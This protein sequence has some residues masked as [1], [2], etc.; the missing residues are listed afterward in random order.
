MAQNLVRT[1]LFVAG[2]VLIGI[3]AGCA[4][5]SK[6]QCEAGDWLT[7]GLSDGQHGR[8]LS[9]FE[10]HQSACA[11]HG[12]S[13]NKA[14]YEDGRTE[15]LAAYC[16]L[17]VAEREGLAGRPY[18]SV[19]TGEM[20]A[21]FYHVHSSARSVYATSQ[22]IEVSENRIDTLLRQLSDPKLPAEQRQQVTADLTFEQARLSRLIAQRQTREGELRRAIVEETQRLE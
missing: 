17:E 13:V 4:T 22:E 12:I 20:G 9:R 19:C 16:R 10:E 14:L 21:A 18:H 5:L 3:L 2:L 7:I 6:E 1:G 15:G 11:E 8:P